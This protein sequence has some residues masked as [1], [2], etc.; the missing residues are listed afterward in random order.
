MCVCV[1]V[2]ACVCILILILRTCTNASDKTGTGAY[3]DAL[4]RCLYSCVGRSFV[5]EHRVTAAASEYH[6]RTSPKVNVK[7]FMPNE[8]KE[9]RYEGKE[10]LV[11]SIHS[12][13]VNENKTSAERKLA[14]FISLVIYNTRQWIGASQQ[15]TMPTFSV[16]FLCAW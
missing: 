6:V 16:N 13:H 10:W 14:C 5:R 9:Q 11:R 4:A 3:I 1:Y 2:C 12:S 7:P 8:T 15:G